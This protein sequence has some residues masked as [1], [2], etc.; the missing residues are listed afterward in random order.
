MLKNETATAPATTADALAA[1]SCEPAPRRRGK[2]FKL[3][4]DLRTMPPRGGVA[5]TFRELARLQAIDVASHVSS[6]HYLKKWIED[7]KLGELPA[8]EITPDQLR[9]GCKAMEAAGYKRG[10]INRDLSQIGSIYKWAAK[11]ELTPSAFISPTLSIRREADQIRYVAPAQGDEWER[12]RLLAKGCRNQKFT[13]L[14]WLMMDTGARRGRDPRIG[15]G[16]TSTSTT[17]KAPRSSSSTSR[18]RPA[19]RG[20]STSV[21]RQPCWSSDCAQSR[22]GAASAST[23]CAVRLSAA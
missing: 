20:A 4:T 14:V 8:W 3:D 12:I 17:R 18:R 16:P 7:F 23:A 11:K 19:S 2:T 13:L 6:L 21:T 9:S 22:S 10:T 5:L 15:C 1:A